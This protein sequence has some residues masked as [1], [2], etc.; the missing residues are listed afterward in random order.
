[1]A[2]TMALQINSQS[3]TCRRA[4]LSMMGTVELKREEGANY[5][6]FAGRTEGHSECDQWPQPQPCNADVCW[7]CRH[8]PGFPVL[9]VN[10]INCLPPAGILPAIVPRRAKE[11]GFFRNL[12][13]AES[14]NQ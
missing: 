7:P 1:M 12:P 11:F 8:L 3:A 14:A 5:R 6:P 9:D 4:T 2:K 13:R 10:Q